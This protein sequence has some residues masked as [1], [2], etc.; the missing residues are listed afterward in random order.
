MLRSLWILALLLV[1]AC[2]DTPGG[3]TAPPGVPDI[4]TDGYFIAD[5]QAT[6]LAAIPQAWLAA[7]KNM[8]VHLMGRSH[9]TQVTVGLSLL[10]ADSTNY[11]ST[12]GWFSLPEESGALCLYGAQSGTPYCDFAFYLNNSD[13]IPGNFSDAQNIH[14][15]LTRAPALSVSV[16]LWCRDLDS[17]TS[18]QV[19]DYLVQLALLEAQYTNVK[20][21]Y[22]TGNADADGAAGHLRARNNRQIREWV[23]LGNNRFLFDYEDII[24]HAWNGSAWMQSTYALNGTNVPFINPAYNPAIN[25]PEYEYTHANATGCRE[26]AKAFWFLLARIAGWEG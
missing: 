10:E 25:G 3:S 12:S 8:K 23:K 26:V 17:M 7:A 14:A 11:S 5:H 21:V 15:V 13:G 4:F 6:A 19:N 24:T 9:S 2:S 16:F 22:A 18:N 1:L 20:F